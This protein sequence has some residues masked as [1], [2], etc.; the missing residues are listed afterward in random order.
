MLNIMQLAERIIHSW[1]WHKNVDREIR[2]FLYNRFLRSII[3]D[4][5]VDF[6][7]FLCTIIRA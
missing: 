1:N 3:I 7:W 6:H 5:I 2:I 4:R